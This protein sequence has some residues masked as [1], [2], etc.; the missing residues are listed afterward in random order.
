M[1]HEVPGMLKSRYILRR[2]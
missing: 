2:C 1:D